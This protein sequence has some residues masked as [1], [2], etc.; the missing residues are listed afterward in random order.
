MQNIENQAKKKKKKKSACKHTLWI[1]DAMPWSDLP[2][3]A[4]TLPPL[5]GC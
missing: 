2:S 5:R 3:S 1:D 4:D